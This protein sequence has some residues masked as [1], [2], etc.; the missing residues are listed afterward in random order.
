MRCDSK[1][2]PY[3]YS[4]TYTQCNYVIIYSSCWYI[5]WSIWK[6]FKKLQAMLL[7]HTTHANGRAIL[8]CT[9]HTHVAAGILN[10]SCFVIILLVIVIICRHV[11]W[12]RWDW[13]MHIWLVLTFYDSHL[14]ARFAFLSWIRI[15]WKCINAPFIGVH[16]VYVDNSKQNDSSQS[17][18]IDP[19]MIAAARLCLHD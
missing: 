4:R 18:S 17:D 14:S 12:K 2:H 11:I 7:T 16:T 15:Y 13:L 10:W 8:N 1:R 5:R 3:T 6:A 9:Q 19:S